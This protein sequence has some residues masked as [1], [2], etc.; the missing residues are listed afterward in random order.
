MDAKWLAMSLAGLGITLAAANW[1]GPSAVAAAAIGLGITVVGTLK[2]LE[3]DAI[4]D[5]PFPVAPLKYSEE[6]LAL[7]SLG[8]SMASFADTVAREA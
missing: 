8:Y 1:H 6:A 5:L 3:K 4:D 7:A 2:T